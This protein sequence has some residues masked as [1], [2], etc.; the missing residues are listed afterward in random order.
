MNDGQQEGGSDSSSLFSRS[1]SS[2]WPYASCSLRQNSAKAPAGYSWPPPCSSPPRL[3]LRPL[4][5]I[6]LCCN[7]HQTIYTLSKQQFCQFCWCKQIVFCIQY[8]KLDL[9]TLLDTG[10]QCQDVVFM[11]VL[12]L[13]AV[14]VIVRNSPEQRAQ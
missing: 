13:R 9:R 8:P 10:H 7:L 5:S 4:T 11:I 1:G 3:Q 14:Q 2:S 12:R 6:T